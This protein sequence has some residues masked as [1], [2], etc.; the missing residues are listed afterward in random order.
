MAESSIPANER[1]L[2]FAVRH[3]TTE[4]NEQGILRAWEIDLTLDSRGQIDAQMAGQ[5]LKAY[6]PKMIY[7]SDLTRDFQTAQIIAAICGNV[8][9]EVDYGLRTANVG[10]LSGQDE[11]ATRPFFKRWYTDPWLKAPSGESY[12]DFC[13]RFDAAWMPKMELAREVESFRPTVLV[14]HGR[15]LARLH[16]YFSMVPP[17]ESLMPLPGGMAK[18]T[19]GT[20][21]LDEFEWLGPTEPILEDR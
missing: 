16:S 8:P 1:V 18:I 4:G 14:S 5:K 6:K 3:G 9:H 15:N 7:S 10:E 21:G 11:E 17:V 13:R 12:N 19:A 20:D 2:I